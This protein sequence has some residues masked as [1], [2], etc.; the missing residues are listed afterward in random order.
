MK[1]DR[2][3]G[4]LSILLKKDR[5]TAPELASIFEVSRRTIQR[6][7]DALS[8]AGI[9]L[10]T[11]QGAGGGVSIMENYRMNQ[12]LLT[13]ADMQAILAGLRSLD[14]VSGTG[15]YAR[16]MEK[17]CPGASRM[18]PGDAHILIDLASWYKSDLSEK[19]ALTRAAME[20]CRLLSFH[21]LSPSG[22]SD[23][24]I[25]PYYLLFRWSSWYVWGWCRSRRDFRLFKL[26]R[27]TSLALG[28]AFTPRPAPLPD[29]SDQRVF[30][31]RFRVRMRV[32]AAYKWRLTE[33]F[34]PDCFT[35]TETGDCLF[36]AGFTDRE[37]A[38]SWALSFQGAAELLEPQE[39]RADMRKI[40]E[41]IEALHQT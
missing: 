5:V 28:D 21:Y 10:R 25:E 18:L 33:E 6:D 12:S 20:Q 23:R 14:S 8:R 32:S 37:Q 39:L 24:V 2:L 34:G 4:I 15:E 41:K 26:N 22:E 40:G 11:V 13:G 9:P 35:E 1:I 30:P 38:L 17:L 29:L 31:E 19:I 7:L 27:I 36:S 16:L 3:I